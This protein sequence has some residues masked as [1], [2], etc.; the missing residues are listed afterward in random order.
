MGFYVNPKTISPA[1]WFQANMQRFSGR[2][3]PEHHY[4]KDDDYVC[5]VMID[6]LDMVNVGICYS[7]FE[8]LRFAEPDGRPKFFAYFPRKIVE[9]FLFGQAI[10]GVHYEPG[11]FVENI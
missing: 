10:E 8:M 6:S 4:L 7:K 1:E 3:V 11:S 2:K 9:P 5:C